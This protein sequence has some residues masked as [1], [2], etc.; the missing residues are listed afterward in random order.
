MKAYINRTTGFL[1][2]A[3]LLLSASVSLRA[4]NA[5]IL[6]LTKEGVD[7]EVVFET[8][9]KQ[10]K[11]K[12]E[13][14]PFKTSK[15][16]DFLEKV[17]SIDPKLMIIMDNDPINFAVKYN[18]ENSKKIQTLSLMGL[19]LKK[20]L[21][22]NQSV[23]GVAYEVPFFTIATKF[24]NLTKSTVN[25]A[26]VFYRGSI[27][28]DLIKETKTQLAV[29]KIKLEAIDV[30]KVAGTTVESITE[31]LIAKGFDQAQKVDVVW[32]MLDSFLLKPEIIQKF[33]IPLANEKNKILL[34]G[35]RALVNPK[36][37][38][39]TFGLSPNLEDLSG[40]ISQ[41]AEVILGDGDTC[42]QVGVENL[43]S[44]HQY[45]NSAMFEKHSLKAVSDEKIEILE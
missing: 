26:L 14:I 30:E 39:A 19:N 11:D 44:V 20:L 16:E 42:K 24:R 18:A 2:T 43:I 37:K 27:F 17:K 1:L 25:S 32:L 4:D 15:D 38:L 5:K 28:E 23:C 36:L 7:F 33:W 13:V 22:D 8:V 31:Y 41:Q 10:L 29:E 6:F 45:G 3:G 34:T 12:F 9:E 35:T 21:K 40:Q